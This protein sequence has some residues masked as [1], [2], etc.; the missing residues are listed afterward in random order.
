MRI[1][2]K[3]KEQERLINNVFNYAKR[4]GLMLIRSYVRYKPLR[5]L[6]MTAM[7][8]LI[9]GL[10]LG[11]RFLYL[12]SMGDA[13]HVQSLI[14]AAILL[15]I[16]FQIIVLAFIADTINVNRKIEEEILY[17]IKKKEFFKI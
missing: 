8:P 4:A 15:I 12:Y 2:K 10:F 9:F 3:G 17:R 13:G 14:L 11:A 1:Q 6:L 5:A 16:S 7:L